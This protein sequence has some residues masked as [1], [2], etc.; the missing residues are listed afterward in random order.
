MNMKK[1]SAEEIY[2]KLHK[3][4]HRFPGGYPATENGVEIKILRKLFT[5]EQAKVTLCLSQK[6]A[7]ASAIAQK[8][9]GE[10]AQTAEM[11]DSMTTQGLIICAPEKATGNPLYYAIQFMP[12]IYELQ[13]KTLDRE[14]SELMEEYLPYL[15][16]VWE[17]SKTKQFRIVP[18]GAS[19]DPQLTVSSY[20]QIDE[21]IKDVKLIAVAPC[22]CT[23]EKK[24]LGTPCDRPFE[25]CL[26]FNNA[27]QRYIDQKK[28]R[29]INK[30]ELLAILKMGEANALVPSLLNVQNVVNI[31]LCCKCCCAVL[32]M[33][34]KFPRPAEQINSSFQAIIDPNLCISCAICKDRCQMD[35]IEEGENGYEVN[36][37]RC[38]G[39]GLCITHCTANAIS[40][41]PKPMITPVP[42]NIFELR[43][44]IS[45]DRGVF[46]DG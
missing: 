41:K 18:I 23:E 15:T 5:P 35:A 28:A 6:P 36:K 38:I 29:Q 21:L 8:L 24:L 32:R 37:G 1:Y 16:K 22:I 7:P 4:L 43:M 19:I 30:E 25:R 26:V 20:D 40:F 14:L 46:S 34:S 11:L 31:C 9:G 3:F 42:K 27:A 12:G 10:E 39:C 33:L 13:V 44:N 17:S 45:K 2:V